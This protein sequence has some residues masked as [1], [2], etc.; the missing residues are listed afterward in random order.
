MIVQ[1]TRGHWMDGKQGVL[2]SEQSGER[3]WRDNILFLRGDAS[4]RED[5]GG[6]EWS[7]SSM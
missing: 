7:Q 3:T 2:H 5:F 4:C 1:Q 6:S